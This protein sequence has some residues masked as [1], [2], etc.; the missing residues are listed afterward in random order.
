MYHCFIIGLQCDHNRLAV[1][2]LRRGGE[3]KKIKKH[4]KPAEVHGRLAG[5]DGRTDGRTCTWAVATG[6]LCVDVKIRTVDRLLHA[7]LG[8]S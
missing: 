5:T 4:P 1:T 8:V 7:T 6:D 2:A 3:K